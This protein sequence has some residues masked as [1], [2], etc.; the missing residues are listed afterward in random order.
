MCSNNLSTS[1]LFM[2]VITQSHK[3][4]VIQ[5]KV[6]RDTTTDVKSTT[7]N[8]NRS[9]YYEVNIYEVKVGE[10]PYQASLQDINFQHLCGATIISRKKLLTAAHCFY[11][12]NYREETYYV[13]AGFILLSSKKGQYRKINKV[14]CHPKFNHTTL[15]HDIAIIT[16]LE[17]FTFN[18]YVKPIKFAMQRP[19]EYQKCIISGWGSI[20]PTRDKLPDALHAISVTIQ[21]PKLCK[22]GIYENKT[23]L[24]VGKM[25]NGG[26]CS[27]D[28]GGPLVCNSQ[29]CGIISFS[30][31]YCGK[32]PDVMT[33]VSYYYNFLQMFNTNE[34]KSKATNFFPVKTYFA[35][36]L[37]LTI[38]GQN[39][40]VVKIYNA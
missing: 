1:L 12:C 25:G 35:I 13:Q 17:E 4:T 16:V 34:M 11:M 9:W 8:N 32:G 7:E 3:I 29:L 27:G 20:Q 18:N 19:N 31:S 10:I 22:Y 37:T 15:I 5:S 14:A 28:S 39:I 6:L 33:D 30:T 40:I 36:N 26:T 24:C 38:L 21:N 2:L 23:M